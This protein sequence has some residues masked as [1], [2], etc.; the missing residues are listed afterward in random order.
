MNKD[1]LPNLLSIS[2][3]P[4]L[5]VMAG[6][7]YLDNKTALICAL[8]L[9]IF[10]ALTDWLDGYLARKFNSI[11]DLGK[12]LDAVADKIFIIGLFC[13]LLTFEF[14]PPWCLFLVLIVIAREFLITMLR[15]VAATRGITLAAGKEGKTKTAFQMIS[16]GV[17]LLAD[18]FACTV[19]NFCSEHWSNAL[20]ILG[21]AFFVISVILTVQSGYSYL[22]KYGNFFE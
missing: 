20:Y 3:V 16:I 6:L 17:L 11:S 13:A 1:H 10:A 12:L 5:F 14:L 15:M 2:R 8:L 9:L 4:I 19:G 22:K 7:L 21:V 18:M